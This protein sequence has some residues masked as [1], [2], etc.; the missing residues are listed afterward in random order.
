MSGAL[1]AT[2]ATIGGAGGGGGGGG[3]GGAIVSPMTLDGVSYADQGTAGSDPTSATVLTFYPNGTW[4]VSGFVYGDIDSGLWWNPI[5]GGIGSSYWIRFTLVS[6]S[7]SPTG[8]TWSTSTGWLA[9]TTNNS[10]LVLC[11]SPTI[12]FRTA[13]YKIEISSSSGGTPVVSTA[14]VTLTAQLV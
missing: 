5:T 13:D 9:M 2:F 7:G 11:T 3:G 14:N 4:T 12:K 8:T 6:T 1:A 10:C